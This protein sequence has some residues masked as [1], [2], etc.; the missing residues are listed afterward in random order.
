MDA[1][2]IDLAKPLREAVQE[3]ER[4]WLLKAIAHFGMNK[5]QIALAAG[6]YPQNISAKLMALRLVEVGQ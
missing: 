3:L 4:A 6:Y 2:A 5:R 1:I